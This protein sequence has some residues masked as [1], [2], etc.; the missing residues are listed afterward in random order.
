MKFEER[1]VDF[2]S[3]KKGG[4]RTHVYEFTNIGDATLEIDYVDHCECTEA[5][6]PRL[7][8]EPGKTGK[9]TVIFDSEDKDEPETI[10]V[11]I[12]LKNIDPENEL[13][14]FETI[15]YKFTIE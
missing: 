8:I 11:N 2:G 5:D 12:F 14:I 3:I 10:D 4:K 9:I 13:N 15:Q 6:Y 7:P 1:I